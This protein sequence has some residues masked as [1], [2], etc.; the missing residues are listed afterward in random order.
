MVVLGPLR[1]VCRVGHHGAMTD[2]R[3]TPFLATGVGLGHLMLAVPLALFV[4][5]AALGFGLLFVAVG[6]LVLV[7]LVPALA[8]FARVHT[9]M[10]GSFLGHPVPAQTPGR[11]HW[12]PW[13]QFGKWAGSRAFWQ[14]VLWMLYAASFGLLLSTL[15]GALPFGALAMVVL[16]IVFL[17]TDPAAHATT[18]LVLAGC[19][20]GSI[21]V[22]WLLGDRLLRWRCELDAAI[23]RPDPNAELHQR[24]ADL[25]ASRSD[26]IDDSAAELR[27]IERD[28]HD[29]AQ[30]R[31]V[32]LGMTL[33]MAADLLDR[34][35]ALARHL[36]QEAR[37]TTGAALGDLRAVVR[38]IHPPVLAD[39]GLIAAVQAL[40]LDL[41]MPVT[42]D[43]A[44]P[45][46]LP[47]AVETA[48]YFAVAECLSNVVK[49]ACASSAWVVIAALDGR[50]RLM[51]GD[52]GR[53]GADAA[54]GSGL[55]GLRRRLAAF[56]GTVV[57]DSP[58]GGPTTVT[59]SLLVAGPEHTAYDGKRGM[60]ERG[61]GRSL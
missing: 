38:G 18:C 55:S 23:L 52:N 9:A 11:T 31:L 14:L 33:G 37:E 57:V 3:R 51:V 24:V 61:D 2:T 8:A 39:R 36:L 56:D 20:V 35:P 7:P 6:V 17:A 10:A 16:T 59:M 43:A 54:R 42:V 48:A 40:A 30:A 50:L 28:L 44:L 25:T 47:A 15:A 45:A 5:A 12:N 32:A 13:V 49:H 46:R 1:G 53:G 58:I 34:D 21:G 19:A 60:G 27:R 29:G 41:P 22:W 4:S 26:T